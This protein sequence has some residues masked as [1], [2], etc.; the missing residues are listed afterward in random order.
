MLALAIVLKLDL[1]N[2]KELLRAS[3]FAFTHASKADMIV[4]YFIINENWDI[5]EI[6]STLDPYKLKPL[7]C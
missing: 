4:E 2:T 7:G 3:G 1:P 6:N 5:F